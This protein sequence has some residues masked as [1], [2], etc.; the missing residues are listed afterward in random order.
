MSDQ[1]LPEVPI[2]GKPPREMSA[3]FAEGYLAGD[4]F[5]YEVE[6]Y[7][8]EDRAHFLAGVEARADDDLEYWDDEARR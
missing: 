6:A 2:P 3:A 1:S 7:A 8:G 4:F 5:R